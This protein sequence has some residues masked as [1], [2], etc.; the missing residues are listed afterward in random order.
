MGMLRNGMWVRTDAGVGIHVVETIAVDK[1]GN[2]RLVSGAAPLKDGEK[3][4]TE[5]W[6][7]ITNPDGTTLAQIPAANAGA[8]EQ[9][10]RGDIP[11]GRVEHLTDDRLAELGYA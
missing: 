3:R 4:D 2:R 10:A 6:V 5:A 1:D 11:A 7:H 8:I 9:A